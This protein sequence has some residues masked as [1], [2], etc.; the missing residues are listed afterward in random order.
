MK[1]NKPSRYWSYI[2]PLEFVRTRKILQN[3]PT[4][5]PPTREQ[6][7]SLVSLY[8]YNADTCDYQPDIDGNTISLSTFHAPFQYWLNLDILNKSMV[9]TIGANI[10]LHPLLIEDILNK[11]QRPKTEEID[12]L[13]TCVLHML[14]FNDE[15]KSIESEQ[16]TFVIGP[17]FLIS[18]QDECDRD[19]FNPIRE[20]LS[21]AK[22][23]NRQFGV[24]YLLYSLIDVIVDHYFVVLDKLAIEIEHLEEDI[25]RGTSDTY[26]MNR[27]NDIR[28]ELMLF[29]RFVTPV[30]ELVGSII[31]SESNRFDTRSMNYF[32]DIYDHIIQ[33]ND[34]SETYRD[35]ISSLRDLYLNQVNL[36]MNQVMKLMA[37]VTT[38]LAPATV[39][40]G[41]FGMNFDRI[42]Y[43]HNQYGFW[44]AT[45][46]MLLIPMFMLYYFRKK[47][48]F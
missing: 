27:I 21:I 8:R 1:K 46:F 11:N 48:W 10:G 44:I 39:I 15:Q 4:A 40:G 12:N 30:R 17:H 38:L 22:T 14:Y 43:L 25:V 32:K 3:N 36:K 19:L 45:F 28:K 24:D 13:F 29:K 35:V 20:K 9:E 2:N 26:A 41:V 42:P 37:I 6:K 34:L 7:K 23:R 5:P 33:A 47:G 16:V 31:R 18:F